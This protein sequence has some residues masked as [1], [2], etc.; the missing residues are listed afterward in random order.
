M[1]E[2]ENNNRL[3]ERLNQNTYR[4]DCCEQEVL[5]GANSRE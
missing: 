5:T 3:A 1:S 2:K 4:S